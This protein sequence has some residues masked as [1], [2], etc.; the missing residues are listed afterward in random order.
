MRRSQCKRFHD[1]TLARSVCEIMAKKYKLG[2]F[3]TSPISQGKSQMVPIFGSVRS[4]GQGVL[5][6]RADSPHSYEMCLF[7]GQ[8]DGL[9]DGRTPLNSYLTRSADFVS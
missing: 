5:P 3:S 6:Q 8:T 7:N 4:L 1:S 2:H 9:T